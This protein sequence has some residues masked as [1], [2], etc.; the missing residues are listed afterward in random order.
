MAVMRFIIKSHKIE[1]LSKADYDP[2]KQMWTVECVEL[3]IVT[4][5]K[6]YAETFDRLCHTVNSFLKTLS[7][8]A[9]DDMLAY[10]DR[11]DIQ[12]TNMVI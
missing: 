11:L 9:D 8:Y 4:Y 2:H 5:G 10:F 7:A 12:H 6:T 3:G 1:L